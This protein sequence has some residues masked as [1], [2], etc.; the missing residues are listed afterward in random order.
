MV[1]TCNEEANIEIFVDELYQVLKKENFS[2]ELLFVD[3]S[4][5]RTYELLL[6]IQK[7]YPNITVL[8]GPNKGFGAALCMSL[9]HCKGRYVTILMADRSETP[10]D[11][12]RLLKKARE[13]YDIVFGSRFS[14]GARLVDYP[15]SKLIANRLMNLLINCLFQIRSPDITG[16]FKIYNRQFIFPHLYQST[17]FEISIEIPLRAIKQGARYTYIPVTYRNRMAGAAKFRISKVGWRYLSIALKL[18][19]AHS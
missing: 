15:I 18:F 9:A 1:P 10:D 17:G 14:K 12:P 2:Y 19:L 6:A 11:V 16:A 7:V 8:K 3:D 13:G 5:D 4:N